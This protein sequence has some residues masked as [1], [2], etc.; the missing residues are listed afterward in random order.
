MKLRG[1]MLR[2]ST[3]KGHAFQ[4][5]FLRQVSGGLACADTRLHHSGD[6]RRFLLAYAAG[7]S[8]ASGRPAATPASTA[9]AMRPRRRRWLCRGRIRPNSAR[10]RTPVPGGHLFDQFEH[11]LWYSRFPLLCCGQTLQHTLV[12]VFQRLD[13]ELTGMCSLIL[14]ISGVG[15]PSS[16]VCGQILAIKRPSLVLPWSSSSVFQPG[17]RLDRA[18]HRRLPVCLGLSGRAGR[19]WST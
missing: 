7:F 16:M 8:T 11:C 18:T 6:L 3:H 9:P 4:P 12:N 2:S 13:V 14:W 10:R 5:G 15:G 19:Q 1:T 17:L